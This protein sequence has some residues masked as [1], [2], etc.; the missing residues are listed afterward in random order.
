MT[1]S[2]RLLTMSLMFL[3]AAAVLIWAAAQPVWAEGNDGVKTP[4]KAE[5]ESPDEEDES[6]GEA[7][8][9]VHK[10]LAT[11]EKNHVLTVAQKAWTI[12]ECEK[13]V[14]EIIKPGM[15]DLEK[16]YT[17]AVWVNKHVEYDWEFWSGGYNFDF[18][19]HQWDAYGA[20]MGKGKEKSVCVGIAIFYANMCH[21]ADLPCRVVRLDPEYLDHTINYIPDINGHA[22]Y[23]DVTE[24]CFLMTDK[25]G[26]AF[27]AQA[28]KEFAK[29]TKD[30]NDYTFDY[31]VAD[32]ALVGPELKDAKGRYAPYADFF[33]E[34]ALHKKTKKKF[35]T[36]YVE[37]GS[38]DGTYHASYTDPQYYPSQYNI[39]KPSIW[40]L[41]DFYDDPAAI[42]DKVL[43]REFDEQL[44][45]AAGVRSNYDCDTED[46]LLAAVTADLSVEYF[47]TCEGDQ[48][49]AATA[50]LKKDEQYRLTCT[51]FDLAAGTAELEIAAIA[52]YTGTY[53]MSVT[54]N[55]AAV[56][57]TP[58]ARTGLE[59]KGTA[60]KL[61]KAGTAVN[62]QMLYALGTE[63]EPTGE[64]TA[65]IPT[66]VDAGKYYVWYKAAGDETHGD[67]QPQ[68]LEKPV[69]VS[70]I[71]LLIL[72]D[73]QTIKVGQTAQL[74][75]RLETPKMTA[76]YTYENDDPS[77]ATVDE[78]GLVTGIKEG[79]VDVYVTGKL[80]EPDPN[81]KILSNMV[82]VEVEK[83]ANPMKLKAKTVKVSY[84]TL[85]K[86]PQT[87]E[88]AE[89]FTVSKAEGTLAYKLVSAK[90]GK[91]KVTKAFSVDGETGQI[92]VQQGLK[93]GKYKVKVKVKAAGDEVYYKASAWKP[94]TFTVKV[95]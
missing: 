79:T 55:S 18:Y 45:N 49:V 39:E 21:A 54:L 30:A 84:K 34:F 7:V 65:E 93:K 43:N 4:K 72:A 74:N 86:T 46:A 62:G 66:A 95:R 3:L 92:T 14:S 19:S 17:L 76:T 94:V 31:T 71:K 83:Y 50:V 82:C 22:Y 2:R 16:Y 56:E 42:R 41:D 15:S 37:K 67:S 26:A 29:I 52:P 44:L 20:M 25:S 58:A 85:M 47:P 13:V 9:G 8:S 90:K 78:N 38:G 70:P 61:I 89:A 6:D 33:R 64:F 1:I 53:K 68:R 35:E 60:Q 63:T 81:Y 73:N 69:S 11:F 88:A 59:Y 36:P 27:V 57:K 48:V 77:I 5:L 12:Q 51:K 28:D 23:A 32:G 24:N 80:T 10:D 75:P 40:F 91:K 87:I